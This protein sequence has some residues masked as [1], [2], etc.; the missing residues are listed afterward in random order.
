MLPDWLDNVPAD[1]LS[2]L[3]VTLDR[4]DQILDAQIQR[5]S[6]G[7]EK[8]Q[9]DPMESAVGVSAFWSESSSL[10]GLGERPPSPTASTRARKRLK[11]SH[12]CKLRPA[13]TPRL[14]CLP[15]EERTS[16]QSSEPSD[17]SV[18]AHVCESPMMVTQGQTAAADEASCT[19][20]FHQSGAIAY[21]D[22]TLSINKA[23]NNTS[24]M[25]LGFAERESIGEMN[26]SNV[27]YVQVESMPVDA[28]MNMDLTE[29]G[30]WLHLRWKGRLLSLRLHR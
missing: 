20:E 6:R 28:E 4:F 13:K 12:Y 27:S 25:H 24:W 17:L 26:N 7:V 15:I 3:K 10:Q 8:N 16:S 30:P 5:L 1:R 22:A 19:L 11:V 23:V 14:I 9:P 29:T 18:N 21:Y 2:F